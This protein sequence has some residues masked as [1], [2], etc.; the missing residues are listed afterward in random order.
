MVIKRAQVSFEYLIIMGFITFVIV[1]VLGLAVY[2]SGNIRD[3]IITNQLNNCANKI[4]ST[5]ES[6][7]YLGEPSK[8]TI[9]CYLPDGVKNVTIFSDSVYFEIQTSSGVNKIYFDS[10]VPLE[11]EFVFTE[12]VRKIELRA[13]SDR[14][15]VTQV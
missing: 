8:S 14:V 3:R 5:A 6:V 7:F 13:A 15:I 11:G 9:T 4:V 10:N 12:G 1:A 2:Y